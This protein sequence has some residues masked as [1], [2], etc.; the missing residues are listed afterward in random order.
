MQSQVNLIKNKDYILQ[1]ENNDLLWDP[2]DKANLF[3]K[4]FLA[5]E[6]TCQISLQQKKRQSNVKNKLNDGNRSKRYRIH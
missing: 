4:K 1:D 2:S 3:A 6:R 5:K